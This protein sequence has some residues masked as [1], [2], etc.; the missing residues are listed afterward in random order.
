MKVV[1]LNKIKCAI[2]ITDF[3]H[4]HGNKNYATNIKMKLLALKGKIEKVP[5]LYGN[6]IVNEHPEYSNFNHMMKQNKVNIVT[7]ID[8]IYNQL[9]DKMSN[10][11]NIKSGDYKPICNAAG[12]KRK[13]RRA[14]KNTRSRK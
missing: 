12:G 7:E 4:R 11:K 10:I 8:S 14:K 5:K 9:K 1:L 6:N 13:T 2:D 3:L